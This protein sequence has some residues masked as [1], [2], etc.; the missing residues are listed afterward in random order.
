MPIN[1]IARLEGISSYRH[2]PATVVKQES[3]NPIS[4]SHQ[5]LNLGGQV[6]SVIS[7]IAAYGVDYSRRPNKIAHHVTIEPGEMPAA[8][9][10]WLLRQ[11]SIMRSEWLGQ[12][13]TPTNG[14]TIP[15]GDQK[16]TVCSSWMAIAGDAGWGG[17]VAEAI[18]SGSSDPLWVIYPLQHQ[19]RLLEL[20]DEAIALLP[21][22]QRWRATFNTYAANVPP[23]V[24]CKVRFVPTATEEARFAV[25]S[26]KAIDLTKHQS[27]TTA[28]QWVERARG[29]IRESAATDR[30]TTVVEREAGNSTGAFNAVQENDDEAPVESAW[31]SDDDAPVGPPPSLEPPSLPPELMQGKESRKQLWIAVAVLGG[32]V[33]LAST[34][35]VA[36]LMAGLPILPGNVPEQVEEMPSFEPEPEPKIKPAVVPVKTPTT[37]L[38][39][40]LHY[41]KKQI[42]AWALQ[43]PDEETPMPI[44]VSLRG[45]VSLKPA[46]VGGDGQQASS[47]VPS[48]RASGLGSAALVSWGGETRSLLDRHERR[49]ASNQLTDGGYH[50]NVEPL[51]YVP[52]ALGDTEVMLSR[53][54]SSLVAVADLDFSRDPGFL[55]DQRS[56]YRTY[57]VMLSRTAERLDSLENESKQLPETLKDSVDSFLRLSFPRQGESRVASMIRKSGALDIGAEAIKLVTTLQDRQVSTKQL[58]KEQQG[59]LIRIVSDCGQINQFATEL[60]RAFD[61]LEIGQVVEVPE[62][63]FLESKGVE[64]RRVP[65]R[66]HFSW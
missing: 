45:A 61:V 26:G 13:E 32:L 41:D 44:P 49:I 56:A 35:T 43:S 15:Q 7:R 16:P 17:V 62:L 51:P 2:L 36:R 65:I 3:D 27:I 9:P 52:A 53:D 42:L 29:K 64:A 4:Y 10:A 30:G 55:A 66:F 24:E 19:S 54:T 21:A 23:D 20:M 48:N 5:R 28:S 59:A 6:I 63:V 34:W 31:S 58:S 40:K 57:V 37:T 11:R 47:S 22:G 1:V 38:V 39:M 46:A 33:G 14:P 25:S 8:G 18:L 50:V 60:H 12:C